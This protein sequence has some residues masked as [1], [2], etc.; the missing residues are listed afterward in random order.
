M[1]KFSSC[2]RFDSDGHVTTC[3]CLFNHNHSSTC[4]SQNCWTPGLG[5]R[6]LTRCEPHSLVG[7]MFAARSRLAAFSRFAPA[8]PSPPLLFPSNNQHT[9]PQ[10]LPRAP[11]GWMFF[12]PKPRPSL[13]TVPIRI[14]CRACRIELVDMAGRYSFSDVEGPGKKK[15]QRRRQICLLWM[16]VNNTTMS[17]SRH[18]TKVGATLSGIGR[19]KKWGVRRS[20]T[21]SSPSQVTGGLFFYYFLSS[22]FLIYSS[23]Y[24]SNHNH[25]DTPYHTPPPKAS[26]SSFTRELSASP[27]YPSTPNGTSSVGFFSSFQWHWQ[28]RRFFRGAIASVKREM[29]VE[30]VGANR[31]EIEMV[32][33]PMLEQE[34]RRDG[35]RQR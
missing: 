28:S 20:G 24:Q 22:H 1:T 6:P 10:P 4:T 34:R 26:M 14:R 2:P 13:H 30:D 11:T 35:R 12:V 15:D 8:N 33:I 18:P 16:S 21:S 27:S 32:E 29:R 31:L 9:S 17:S 23:F 3:S 5:V 19:I 7:G 25:K